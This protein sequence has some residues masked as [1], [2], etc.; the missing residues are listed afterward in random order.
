MS[1]N[2]GETQMS[3]R[4]ALLVVLTAWADEEASRCSACCS[5]V[6]ELERNLEV[7]KPRMNVDLRRTLAGRDAGKVVDWA[8]SELRTLELLEGICPA[9][10]HYGVTRTDGGAY[11]QRHSVRGGSVHVS[12]SMTIGGERYQHDRG[13]LR[14]YCDRVVEEHEEHLG[15]AIRAAGL[16]QLARKK[17]AAGS[18][19][20]RAALG[21][22]DDADETDAAAAYKRLARE[23]HPD[24]GG[25]R[26]R[27]LAVVDA[28]EAL[29]GR[30]HRPYGDLYRS[31]CVDV[32]GA[33]ASEE[34]VEASKR[35]F[36]RYDGSAKFPRAKKRRKRRRKEL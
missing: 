11:Y 4:V 34:D 10:E 8:A 21:L 27:F 20:P 6:A 35:F 9:M 12:G 2:P 7:E 19:D 26:E 23:L 22:S 25:D 18:S 30:E 31:V 1:E 36:P 33:C 15:E 28:Y 29:T 3:L 5:I 32:V 24:K 17:R 13:F 16:V 14:S